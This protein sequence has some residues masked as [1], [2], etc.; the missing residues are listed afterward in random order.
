MPLPGRRL[1]PL[2]ACDDIDD[3]AVDVDTAVDEGFAECAKGW[4]SQFG[5]HVGI[6]N[7]HHGARSQSKIQ[8]GP[9]GQDEIER[10]AVGCADP[11]S[12]LVNP[13]DDRQTDNVAGD[14]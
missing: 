13:M 3:I 14:P 2:G 11:L 12:Q 9:V 7:G 4:V 1:L 5:E 6:M 10:L 8:T